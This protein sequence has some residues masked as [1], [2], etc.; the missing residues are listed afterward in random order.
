MGASAK[1]GLQAK[2]KLSANGRIVIPVAIRDALEVQP[3]ESLLMDVEDGI[4]RIE[5]YR[6]RI[7]RIQKEFAHLVPPGR[8]VSDELI[9]E[10]RQEALLE[11][12]DLERARELRRIRDGYQSPEN[13]SRENPPQTSQPPES[14][15]A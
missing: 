5:S 12:E 13:K 8:Y 7:R 2:T 4:L 1:S 6:S 9:A 15:V 3:G 14:Q 11:Q 10:R